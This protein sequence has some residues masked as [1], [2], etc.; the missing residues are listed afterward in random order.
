MAKPV[1]VCALALVAGLGTS[2]AYADEADA[3]KLFKA[4]SDYLAQTSP[5]SLDFDTSLEIV[6]SDHQ[7]LMLTSSGTVNVQRPN[8]IQMTRH[9]G[10][11]NV[12]LIFDGTTLTL[13]NEAENRYIQAE[14][15]GTID[16]MIDELRE[17][18]HKPLPGADLL[19]SDVYDQLMPLATDI[20][21][22]GSGVVGGVECD[23][24]AFRNQDIDWQIWIAQGNKPYPCRYVI[25]SKQ[26]DQAPQ[27]SVQ[28]RNWNT[29]SE[30]SVANYEF[31]VPP[32]AEKVNDPKELGNTDELPNEFRGAAQ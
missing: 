29:G 10:F 32:N 31:H 11:A 27:Y 18:F 8:K 21:D 19:L 6:T 28:V 25:T 13:I 24:I 5:F 12:K 30:V 20:K 9:G 15:P 2:G 1:A 7:K 16:H 22:L 23:H 4:M 26:V 3:K 14:V 17:K